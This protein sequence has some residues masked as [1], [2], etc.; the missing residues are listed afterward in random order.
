MP[1]GRRPPI[2][3]PP[4]GRARPPAPT[5]G[6]HQA[7]GPHG[8]LARPAS[9]E[10]QRSPSRLSPLDIAPVSQEIIE[11]PEAGSGLKVPE[12][13]DGGGAAHTLPPA[14]RARPPRKEAQQP[15]RRLYIAA[16]IPPRSSTPTDPS[17]RTN[18]EVV[19][20]GL[21]A[22]ARA[23]RQTGRQRC[24]EGSQ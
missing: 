20:H 23:V 6:S 24:G 2:P 22:P 3:L 10:P 14:P 18:R 15:L 4:A 7:S 19:P 21:A 8:G 5:A 1:K 9:P 16:G 17:A 12:A 13:H 11:D